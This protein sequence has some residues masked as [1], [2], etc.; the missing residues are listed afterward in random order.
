MSEV[1]VVGGRRR[2]G[3][4]GRGDAGARGADRRAAGP[5]AGARGPVA[6]RWRAPVPA[7]HVHPGVQPDAR[8]ERRGQPAGD[9]R[10]DHSGTPPWSGST[11][12]CLTP[13]FAAI[14][15]L[16]GLGIAFR[17]TVRLATR[18]PRSPGRVAVWW[19]GEGLGG[20]LNGGAGP[21]G[22]GA[23]SRSLARGAA[24]RRVARRPAW[25]GHIGR[26]RRGP[27]A[28]GRG[29]LPACATRATLLLAV[30]LAAVIWVFVQALGGILA[31]GATDPNSGPLLALL[32]LAYWPA[33]LTARR[34]GTGH[35]C[36]RCRA[37][38]R[39]RS[40]ADLCPPL[41]G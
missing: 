30:V 23:G 40:P 7:G 2:G 27:C 39:C 8:G 25:T 38:R 5:P 6:A 3:A 21:L 26:A 32:A 37:P 15:L 19:F 41:S 31:S 24:R 10:A 12:C 29:R 36:R 18:P 22:G 17:P 4:A 11:S 16:L 1:A 34:P 9:R 35:A 33:K 20:V 14:Q 28:R 13:I